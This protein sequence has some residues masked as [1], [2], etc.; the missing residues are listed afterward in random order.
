MFGDNMVVDERPPWFMRLWHRYRPTT[1]WGVFL[2]TLAA[3]LLLPIALVSSEMFPGLDPAITLSVVAFV[4]A[5]WLAH[6]QISGPAAAA[7]VLG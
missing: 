7:I 4:L 2:L 5:W 6:R 3:T 1:G